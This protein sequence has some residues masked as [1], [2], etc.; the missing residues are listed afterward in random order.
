MSLLCPLVYVHTYNTNHYSVY[1]LNVNHWGSQ[2]K[3]PI[4]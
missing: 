3:L 1:N 2:T 4:Q